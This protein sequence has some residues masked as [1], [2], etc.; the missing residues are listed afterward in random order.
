METLLSKCPRCGSPCL[1]H[2]RRTFTGSDGCK[3]PDIE[4]IECTECKQTFFDLPVAHADSPPSTA[5]AES[6]KKYQNSFWRWCE[7][8]CSFGKKH[9]NPDRMAKDFQNSYKWP[10]Y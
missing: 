10:S 3:I 8:L 6:D 4:T 9:I 2:D 7:K 5:I 1:V